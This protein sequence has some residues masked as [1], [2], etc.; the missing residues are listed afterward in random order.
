MNVL[1]NGRLKGG[2]LGEML[3]F[4]Q[5]IVLAL[6]LFCDVA[7]GVPGKCKHDPEMTCAPV[8]GIPMS[9]THSHIPHP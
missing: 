2:N 8:L 1:L 6:A 9:N 7:N 5:Q 3:S 4:G